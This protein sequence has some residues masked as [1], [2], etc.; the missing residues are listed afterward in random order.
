M[1]LSNTLYTLKGKE[2]RRKVVV[3]MSVKG[4]NAKKALE[5]TML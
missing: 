2:I 4:T 5:N 3:Y 1:K